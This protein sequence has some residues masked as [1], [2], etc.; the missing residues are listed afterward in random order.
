MDY[1]NRSNGYQGGGSRQGGGYKQQTPPPS[2]TPLPPFEYYEADNKTV[3]PKLFDE[4]AK[5]IAES[6]KGVSGT[7][8]RKIFDEAKRF[9]QLL[10]T[11]S[12]DED[13]K[14]KEHE[15]YI[16]MIKSKVSYQ[17]VRAKE[18]ARFEDKG[19]YENLSEFVAKGI[20]KVKKAN[21]FKVFVALF[22]AV[23]GFYY[24]I[25]PSK[26]KN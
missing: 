26:A 2:K 17:A 4:T 3:N 20:D 22:E 8:L 15:A 18:K 12:D 6:L 25:A 16:R 13:L 21:D 10:E 11:S 14:F 19:G 1:Q 5:S 7:Q 23:Y 9:V 24:E